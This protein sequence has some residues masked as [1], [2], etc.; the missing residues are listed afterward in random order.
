MNTKKMV[1]GAVCIAFGL[2][3]PVV[4]HL[5]GGAGSVFLPMHIPV[6]LAGFCLGCRGGFLVGVIT[7][8]LSSILTTMPPLFPLMP[9]MAVELA[10]YGMA[11]GYFYQTVRLRISTALF[12]TMLAGRSAA[13]F[14]AFV[15]LKVLNVNLSP[16]YYVTGAVV[17]GLPGIAVQFILIPILVIRLGKNQYSA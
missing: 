4:F 5:F 1:F 14:G 6:L 12:L 3:L 8:V 7:P 9:I 17:M 13:M 16:L 11:A 2:I 15:L 10:V